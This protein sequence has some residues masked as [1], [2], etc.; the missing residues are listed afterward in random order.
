[1]IGD[2]GG[3]EIGRMMLGHSIMHIGRRPARQYLPSYRKPCS[4][5]PVYSSV[6]EDTDDRPELPLFAPFCS[7]S[8]W[9]HQ[10]RPSGIAIETGTGIGIR[11]AARAKPRTLT[12]RCRCSRAAPS[13]SRRSP[14]ASTSPAAA[15]T[16]SSSRP[17][18]ARRA[19]GSTTSSSRSRR[20]ATSS[21]STPT[22]VSSS[23]ATTTWSKPIS[24]FRCPAQVEA[25]SANVQ[26]ARHR[27]AASPATSMVE[28]FSSEV[29]ADRR[30]RADARQDLQRRRQRRRPRAGPTATT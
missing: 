22:I 24:T 6:S 23:V 30:V 16:R 14:D 12:A 17:C 27:D 13:A 29:R 18:A 15:A 2:N 9:P 10:P 21:T 26:R 28:G 25:R 1:M 4:D 3:Q 5:D 20:A 11:T 8:S 19:S 7:P